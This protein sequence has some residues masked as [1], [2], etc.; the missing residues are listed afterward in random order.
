MFEKE[1][2]DYLQEHAYECMN[3]KAVMFDMDGVLFDSMKNHAHAWHTA[4]LKYGMNLSYEEAYLHEG[5]TGASTIDIVYSR[6]FG[7]KA[8]DNE[9]KQI[10]KTKTEEF[11]KYP[12]AERMSGALELLEKIKAESLVSMVITGSGQ[13]SLLERLNKNFP[14]IFN[15]ELMVTAFDVKYGKPNP[16][17]YLMGLKKGKL[18]PQETIVIENAPLG[19]EAG[20][21]AGVFTIAVNTGPLPDEVLLDKGANLLFHSMQD[22]CDH[23]ESLLEPLNNCR[24]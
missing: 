22:L 24:I 4:M 23:W 18:K 8:T 11:N 12:K 19:I 10:Y 17:P 9:K 16:E 1:I 21:A 20:V 6:Q 14:N 5:R 7:R 13:K 3:L 15:K 2:K